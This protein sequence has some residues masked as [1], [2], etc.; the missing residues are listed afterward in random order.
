MP[1]KQIL[2]AF[3]FAFGLLMM[4]TFLATEGM[5]KESIVIFFLW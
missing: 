3:M 1:F 4:E 2:V 5:S